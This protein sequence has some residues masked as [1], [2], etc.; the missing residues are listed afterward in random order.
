MDSQQDTTKQQIKRRG[1][2]G[3]GKQFNIRLIPL[4][5]LGEV[6]RNMLV[7]EYGQKAI[8]IDAGFRMPEEDM[9]GVDYIIPNTG[10]FKTQEREILGAILTHGHYD[11]IGAIPY[12]WPR[13][14]NPPIFTGKLTKGIVTNRQEEFR[15]QPKLYIE[16]VCSGQ[17]ITLGPFRVEFFSQNHNIPGNFGL[18]IQTPKGNIVH[19]SDFKFDP[20]PVNDAPT[21]FAKLERMGQR[22]ILLLMCDSTGAENEGHSLSERTIF[23]NLEKIFQEAKGRII[24]STF[25]S[26][27]NR[28]QQLIT[29]AEKYERK[30]AI[31]GFS[32]KSNLEIARTLKY[33][34]VKPDTIVKPNQIPKL[35]DSQISFICTGAQGE[36]GAV[37]MKIATQEYRFLKLKKGDSIIFSSSVIPGNERTV[38]FLKDQFYRQGAHVYHYQIMDIHA[39]GHAYQEEINQ[40]IRLMKPKFFLPVHGQY[41][42]MFKNAELAESQGIPKENIIIA[43]NGDVINLN[44]EKCVIEREKIP[45]NYVMVDGLGVGDVGEV[46]LRDRQTLSQDGMFVIIV[47]VDRLAGKVKGSPDIISRGFVYLRESRELLKETRKIVISIVDKAAGAGGAVNWVYVKDEL[48]NQIGSFLFSKTKRRPMILPV[49]IEV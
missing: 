5:G 46:V 13:I 10:Y 41:S 3:T 49:V 31:E 45:S 20:N 14:G 22:G 30:V 27:I 7:L 12:L 43:E 6:G 33:I 44:Q 36:A 26:H 38:Q 48:R 39:S 35:H 18:F 25:A 17:A 37:F 42:M 19:S 28:V 2:N 21:D 32:L 9:P 47:A 29:L 40:M 8:I 16:E 4:G 15:N 23:E 34:Q 11:H 1:A 24:S